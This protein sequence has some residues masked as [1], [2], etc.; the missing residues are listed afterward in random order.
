M[1]V[2]LVAGLGL[3]GWSLSA[4]GKDHRAQY[5]PPVHLRD[6]EYPFDPDMSNTLLD[7]DTKRIKEHVRK[8]KAN[9]DAWRHGPFQADDRTA[10]VDTDRKLD[11]FTGTNQ[12]S[13]K[14]KES[15]QPLFEP[16]EKR[17]YVTSGGKS[18]SQQPMYDERDYT[19]RSVFVGKMN[20]VLPFGQQRVGPGLG[21]DADVPSADGLHST[22]RVMPTHAMN[23]HRINQLPGRTASGAAIVTHGSKRYDE[24]HQK[25]PSLVNHTPNIGPGRA[26]FQGQRINP[27]VDHKPTKSEGVNTHEYT[28]TTSGAT[29]HNAGTQTRA[30]MHTQKEQ[31]DGLPTVRNGAV[32]AHATYDGCGANLRDLKAGTLSYNPDDL[33]TGAMSSHAR[34]P[35]QD[36]SFVMKPTTRSSETPYM[37]GG[38]AVNAMGTVRSERV[39]ASTARELQSCHNTGA[40]SHLKGATRQAAYVMGPGREQENVVQHGVLQGGGTYTSDIPKTTNRKHKTNV[41]DTIT[42][43]HGAHAPFAI[44]RESPGETTLSRKVPSVNPRNL[45]EN[46]GLGLV[47][48][49]DA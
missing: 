41:Y 15:F 1:E 44:Q 32:W 7:E 4:P 46:M 47:C 35:A 16:N 27:T 21:Y 3:L 19:D 45:P 42:A 29:Y 43:P 11:L 25:T 33:F 48:V 9:I 40:S 34:G 28:V 20:N 26:S 24:F 8:S 22:F 23:E 6:D 31:L 36:T 10:S 5:T 14:H 30:A 49:E 13:W 18:G 37:T 17:T 39:E 12:T 38:K 2:L